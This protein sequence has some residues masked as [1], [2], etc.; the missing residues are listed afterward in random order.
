M[1]IICNDLV[2]DVIRIYPLRHGDFSFGAPANIKMNSVSM[3]FI[4]YEANGSPVD[5]TA[6]ILHGLRHFTISE[7]DLD[8]ASVRTD[9]PCFVMNE[10][11][12]VKITPKRSA[13]GLIYSAV[14]NVSL[15]QTDAETQV[16]LEK[17]VEHRN[18]DYILELADG[19]RYL[20]RALDGTSN[21]EKENQLKKEQELSLK[22]SLQSVS[23]L[24]P[25]I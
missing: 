6:E 15:Y 5:L 14:M 12:Q 21:V 25:I 24:I 16:E 8:A 13:I 3:E 23:S 1:N 4:K 7:S 22:C 17:M 11:P 2:S 10:Q 18:Y 19:S 9:S 20:L